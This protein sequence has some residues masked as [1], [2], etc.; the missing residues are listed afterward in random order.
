M[1]YTEKEEESQQEPGTN[2]LSSFCNT[3][4]HVVA[5]L[6]SENVMYMTSTVKP[7]F[8]NKLCSKQG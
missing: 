4:N 5:A 7:Y 6:A 1:C 8:F 2:T 3:I